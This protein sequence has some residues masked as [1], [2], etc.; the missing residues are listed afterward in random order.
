MEPSQAAARVRFRADLNYS[1]GNDELFKTA[2]HF[3]AGFKH[4][5]VGPQTTVL[6]EALVLHSNY[7]MP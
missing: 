2:H 1:L 6:V 7:E 3:V 5:R 4:N